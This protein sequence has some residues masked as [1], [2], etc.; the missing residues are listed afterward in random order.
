MADNTAGGEI[1]SVIKNATQGGL[2][3]RPERAGLKKSGGVVGA[4]NTI[5]SKDEIETKKAE[6][7]L[8]K[9]IKTPTVWLWKSVAN[10][11]KSKVQPLA[12]IS[13]E[14]PDIT[15]GED[16]SQE[17][18]SNGI[19][20]PQEMMNGVKMDV[21]TSD[22]PEGDKIGRPE[23]SK[24]GLNL[25]KWVDYS[26]L[27]LEK[28]K[29]KRLNKGGVYL[30]TSAYNA[31]KNGWELTLE[32]I[33]GNEEYKELFKGVD[34]K[35]LQNLI[36][37]MNYVAQSKSYDPN[38]W[39]Y[40]MWENADIGFGDMDYED[41]MSL[42][43]TYRMAILDNIDEKYWVEN[44]GNKLLSPIN[45]FWDFGVKWA[46]GK[47]SEEYLEELGNEIQ[48]SKHDFLSDEEL[49]YTTQNL[50][51]GL[52]KQYKDYYYNQTEEMFTDRRI[53]EQFYKDVAKLRKE[54]KGMSE[55]EAVEK[56]MKEWKY[57]GVAYEKFQHETVDQWRFWKDKDKEKEYNEKL[58]EIESMARR[59][60]WDTTKAWW[61]N[62]LK[63]LW[64]VGTQVLNMASHPVTMVKTLWSMWIGAIEKGA[65]WYIN[66]FN[67]ADI[68]SWKE[69]YKGFKEIVAGWGNYDN[70]EEMMEDYK[71]LAEKGEPWAKFWSWMLENLVGNST[72][73]IN[74]VGDY[75]VQ[76]Y[77]GWDNVKQS[78]YENPVQ[79]LSDVVSLMEWGTMLAKWMGWISPSMYKKSMRVMSFMDPYELGLWGLNKLQYGWTTKWGKK[80]PWLMWAEKWALKTWWKTLK[81]PYTASKW[82]IEN[83]LNKM[84]FTDKE[85]R[86]WVKEHPD[87]VD[88]Y[89]KGDKTAVQIG[90]GIKERL[91]S[92]IE[93]K[94]NVGR[95]Y[96]KDKKVDTS[97]IKD[98][99]NSVLDKV[100]VKLWDDGELTF[101]SNKF[102]ATE[103]MGI[104]KAVRTLLGGEVGG[105][106]EM[107]IKAG[108][109][110]AENLWDIRKKLDNMKIWD[111]NTIAWLWKVA[112][113]LVRDLRGVIDSELKQQVPGWKEADADYSRLL[114][115]IKEFKKWWFD[116]EGNLVDSAYSKIRNLTR[117]GNE[118]K[119]ERLEKYMPW[120][121]NELR[122]LAAAEMLDK[123]SKAIPWQYLNQFLSWWWIWAI[124]ALLTGWVGATA[125]IMWIM[126]MALAT[127]R[128]LATLLRWQWKLEA[129]FRKISKKL[130]EGIKLTATE[131]SELLRY[132]SDNAEWL[133]E[134]AKRLYREWKIDDAEYNE[135]LE[136]ARAKK[137][138]KEK[139]LKEGEKEK[140]INETKEKA[141]NIWFVTEIEEGLKDEKGGKVL[142]LADIKKKIIKLSKNLTDTTAQ[143]ELFHAVMSVVDEKTRKYVIDEAKKILKNRGMSDI[144]AEEWL[145]ESFGIYA[146]RK[147]VNLGVL[148]KVKWGDWKIRNT[149]ENLFQRVYEWLQNYNGDRKTINKLF[150]EILDDKVK[151]WENGW[152]DL[153]YLLG[154]KEVKAGE[155]VKGNWLRYKK[156]WKMEE[157]G[158]T[159]TSQG[160]GLIAKNQKSLLEN[161]KRASGV[162]TT[163]SSNLP[164]GAENSKSALFWYKGEDG[165]YHI[166]VRGN[167][168]KVK[169]NKK[170]RFTEGNVEL[171][172]KNKVY[173]DNLVKW[174]KGLE[175]NGYSD[176][177]ILIWKTSRGKDITITDRKLV[178]IFKEHWQFDLAD[179][180][181][182]VNS[183]KGGFWET[184]VS[185]WFYESKG[186]RPR[187]EKDIP[188][189][190]EVL[191]VGLEPKGWSNELNA[192]SYEVKSFRQ[193][194]PSTIPSREV[195]F[196]KDS[197]GKDLSE[198]QIEYFKNSKIR[199]R[200]GRLIRVYHWTNNDFNAFDESRIGRESFND[201][202][203][204]RWFYF[205]DDGGVAKDYGENVKEWY[206]KMEKPFDMTKYYSDKEYKGLLKE[207]W[208]KEDE[209]PRYEVDDDLYYL[210]NGY[211]AESMYSE[212]AFDYDFNS[213]KITDALKKAG[214]DWVIGDSG[215]S[216]E[217]VVFNSNQ[218][219]NV[220]NL[221]PTKSEDVR[222]KKVIENNREDMKKDLIERAKSGFYDRLKG[223]Q[224]EFLQDVADATGGYAV[225]APLK[226][227]N[228]WEP[229][230][231]IKGKKAERILD[232][233]MHKEWWIRDVNDV[234]RGT[235]RVDTIGDIYKV[236]DY[237]KKNYKNVSDF[238]DKYA[239]PTPMWYVDYSLLF[240]GSEWGKA[241]TQ[242]NAT[243]MIVAK[244]KMKDA[245]NY[246]IS[247]E[248]Y[249][250]IVKKS[251]TKW[252]WLGHTFYDEQR[253][254]ITKLA[255][256]WLSKNEIRFLK[257][258]VKT[259]SR[260][261]RNYYDAYMKLL[262]K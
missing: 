2:I 124:T 229:E 19:F 115:E 237:I 7:W 73:S 29:K 54:N 72:D 175:R 159:T 162:A 119:L 78:V 194:N 193:S 245:L 213:R 94:E 70:W 142:G 97:G 49:K 244:E 79:V 188:W 259:L 16:I 46:T 68:M 169:D 157:K 141:K 260:D 201:W 15:G 147:Q 77:W 51:K 131:T 166:T 12:K 9:K 217:Y 109:D 137:W 110:I 87:D 206:L 258:R 184:E 215:L 243:P 178:H 149:I 228:K 123:A 26:L 230:F 74:M 85:F 219:K 23:I 126:G 181:E 63:D 225:K 6:E 117:K 221:N 13:P 171:S 251:G 191:L 116:K 106:M 11:E 75:L 111:T 48:S 261:S 18:E 146:K 128:N 235:I 24:E 56:V 41:I 134:E 198:G 183:K 249:M 35:K 211:D 53:G 160:G 216:K 66:L 148:D 55:E 125:L 45:F 83:T 27:E 252:G 233:W 104:R 239:N 192:K 52:D 168:V 40:V 21:N 135:A 140:V 99:I 173:Y 96:M 67:I 127:P 145:A 158:Y 190:D 38:L 39:L 177:P 246:G 50:V 172:D 69:D 34:E 130:K 248:E 144:N 90:D 195:R 58:E 231:W 156:T 163:P 103:K 150:D 182:A 65:E 214:Y 139:E 238:D 247:E 47:N 102:T 165:K 209:L 98:K 42:P 262:K 136:K 234:A 129:P 17:V 3:E 89:L 59:E 236:V 196:K 179:L 112:K 197:S 4:G 253:G 154:E 91:D 210:V 121:T 189:K 33:M 257:G 118:M 30:Y 222:Y 107:W 20:T 138:D 205:T 224:D 88:A 151:I 132:M 25:R 64:L 120:I 1:R 199:D 62:V 200:D 143:H 60:H 152:V 204:G 84:T 10:I 203:F 240:E 8:S 187:I 71:I 105:E 36:D 164:K 174:L 86:K 155:W 81:L 242:I 186:L 220:D 95:Q 161:G 207:L 14:Q 113:D 167:E 108:E 5:A 185:K 92:M 227:W 256:G 226:Y 254:I 218:F 153:S 32:Q 31:N 202:F 133:E 212:W 61:G 37:W 114:S 223:E 76:A 57:N 22:L 170:A 93:E 101:V 255:K 176:E 122:S 43:K 241:E 208:L 80:I 180:V 82:M 28:E 100:G 44:I 250:E 232:K